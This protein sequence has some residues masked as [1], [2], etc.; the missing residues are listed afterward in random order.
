MY[1]FYLE[2]PAQLSHLDYRKPLLNKGAQKPKPPPP[3]VAPYRASENDNSN[4]ASMIA[5][6]RK[7]LRATILGMP[8][9]AGTAPDASNLIG[10]S[11]ALGANST[12]LGSAPVNTTAQAAMNN[13]T[14]SAP[15]VASLVNRKR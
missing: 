10:K 14:S 12:A 5:G 3:V 9:G 6:R 7:G 11:S 15:T 4:Q 8:T 2:T 1:D 13:M